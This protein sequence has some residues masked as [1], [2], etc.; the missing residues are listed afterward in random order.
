ML[1]INH[2]RV[3]TA[4]I[5]KKYEKITKKDKTK[6]L[7][8]C[9]NLTANNRMYGARI[10]N[11]GPERLIEYGLRWEKNKI[12]HREKEEKQETDQG[13]ITMMFFEP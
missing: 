13:Y 12:C 7:D 2:K 1:A 8:E 10:L 6:I 3:V 9:I 4:K 5:A 11:N